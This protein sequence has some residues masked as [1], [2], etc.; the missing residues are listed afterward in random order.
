MGKLE[1]ILRSLEQMSA[2]EVEAFT[3]QML[4]ENTRNYQLL[5]EAALR[6]KDAYEKSVAIYRELLRQHPADADTHFNLAGEFWLMGEDE[7]AEH[8]CRLALSLDPSM[9]RA[10]GLLAF[11]SESRSENPAI[12]EYLLTRAER[13]EPQK[14]FRHSNL[15]EFYRRHGRIRE[16]IDEINEALSCRD[17]S[18][19]ERRRLQR[20]LQELQT[21]H[22]P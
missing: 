5:R 20:N 4:A 3:R 15:A 22:D 11:I 10:Y 7:Q 16:A 14:C 17:L 13:L 18:E 1:N 19:D 2:A 12:I 21:A 6:S 9:A 8:E